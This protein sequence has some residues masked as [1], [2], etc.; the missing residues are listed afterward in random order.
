MVRMGRLD[1]THTTV[2]AYNIDSV[3]R[4]E[5]ERDADAA[6][7]SKANEDSQK[8]LNQMRSELSQV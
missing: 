5:L 2:Q 4:K 7:A 3:C 1:V 6:K 8:Y